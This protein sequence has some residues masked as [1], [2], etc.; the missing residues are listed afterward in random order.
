MNKPNYN[1]VVKSARK[2]KG[3]TQQELADQAK[4]SLR[5]VQRVEKGTEE[6]SGFSLR[7]ICNVLD[8]PIETLIMQNVNE[9]S[10]DANQI[11]SIRSLYQ[12]TLYFILFPILGYLIQIFF[13][14]FLPLGFIVPLII[15]ISKPN[16]TTLYKENLRFI[17]LFQG[18]QL[19]I[20]TILSPLYFYGYS[21]YS[22]KI[23]DVYGYSET[24]SSIHMFYEN[25]LTF[26]IPYAIYITVNFIVVFFK[27]KK[28]RP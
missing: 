16:K 27:I 1:E 22:N 10:I 11:G 12:S 19:L 17:L 13:I 15:G 23:Q 21:T 18:F 9:I 4:V 5:T 6:I 14:I 20:F 2:A 25:P 3:L 7:Q 28:L 24:Y 8:I 26:F